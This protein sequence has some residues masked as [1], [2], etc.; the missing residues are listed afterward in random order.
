VVNLGEETPLHA[1]SEPL[2]A[3]PPGAQ[4]RERWSS[5]DP[6]Y[7]GSGAAPLADDAPWRLPAECALLLA[8]DTP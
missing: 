1:A 7:G 6:R 2:T 5:E 4:W 8:P 3:P